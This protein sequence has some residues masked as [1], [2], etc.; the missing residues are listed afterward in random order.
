MDFVEIPLQQLLRV[1]A[2][3]DIK[4]D[5][6]VVL[7][8]AS[9]SMAGDVP[10][11]PHRAGELLRWV[12][13]SETP[14]LGEHLAYVR[15]DGRHLA[16][17]AHTGLPFGDTL[18]I[19][20]TVNPQFSAPVLERV[21]CNAG[22]WEQRLGA[23][24]LLENGPSYFSMPGST[25]SQSEFIAALCRQ[26]PATNLLLDLAHLSITCAKSET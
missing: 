7:H 4:A 8:C 15:A 10:I 6:P 3:I 2:A 14:W 25:M 21:M 5:V 16:G 18:D 24:V 13:E 17:A 12:R 9:L 22:H 26:R 23:P 19:G 11:D 20:Y 1:P